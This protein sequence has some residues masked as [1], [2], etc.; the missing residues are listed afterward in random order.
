MPRIKYNPTL[1]SQMKKLC[2]T[3]IFL[4]D[5]Q[6]SNIVMAKL[7]A[8]AS[9]ALNNNYSNSQNKKYWTRH[10]STRYIWSS[11]FLYPAMQYVI[12]RQ[13]KRMACYYEKWYDEV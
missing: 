11:I 3:T 7:K 8:Y 1:Y 2:N 12:D 4:L 13:G 9:R 10:G 5:E 6:K